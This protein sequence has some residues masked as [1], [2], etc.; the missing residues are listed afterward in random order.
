MGVRD[1]TPYYTG[2][3]IGAFW[4]VWYHSDTKAKQFL[5]ETNRSQCSHFAHVYFRL[6]KEYHQM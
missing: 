1:R 4:D 5:I 2:C 6:S 3:D